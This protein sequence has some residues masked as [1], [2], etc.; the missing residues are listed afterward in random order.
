M[1]MIAFPT[2]MRQVNLTFRKGAAAHRR[3]A[4]FYEN[5]SRASMEMRKT[6]SVPC[7]SSMELNYYFY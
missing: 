5:F 2:L 7:S 6:A 3:A 1:A 4:L